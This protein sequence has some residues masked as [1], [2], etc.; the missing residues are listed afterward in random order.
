MENKTLKKLGEGDWGPMV[1][2]K[3]KGRER[4]LKVRYYLNQRSILYK[5]PT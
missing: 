4:R 1:K 5:L 3:Q 2:P